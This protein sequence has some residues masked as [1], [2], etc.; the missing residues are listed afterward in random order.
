MEKK[1]SKKL[2]DIK[3]LL[4]VGMGAK[5]SVQIEALDQMIDEAEEELAM[6]T[7]DRLQQIFMYETLSEDQMI[8]AMFYMLGYSDRDQPAWDLKTKIKTFIRTNLK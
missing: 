7:E 4:G 2:Q 5:L 8:E 3:E 6:S 1:M